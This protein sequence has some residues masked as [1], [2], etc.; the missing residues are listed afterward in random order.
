M[1]YFEHTRKDLDDAVRAATTRLADDLA[2]TCEILVD[3]LGGADAIPDGLTVV[4][5]A[6]ALAGR[7]A[8]Y[9]NGLAAAGRVST[10]L[11]DK[12]DE[13]VTADLPR[14]IVLVDDVRR[15]LRRHATATEG[16]P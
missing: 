3:A 12:L 1:T 2:R 11:A 4:Q 16:T 13:S 15:V 10:A 5:L 14:R 7:T 6:E 9:R 8:A